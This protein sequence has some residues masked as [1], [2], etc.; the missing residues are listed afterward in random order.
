LN[1]QKPGE[2]QTEAVL[3]ADSRGRSG[4]ATGWR[5]WLLSATARAGVATGFL[6]T[7]AVRAQ[8]GDAAMAALALF[9]AA[10]LILTLVGHWYIVRG[11]VRR[12]LA[13]DAFAVLALVPAAIVAAGIQGAED[14]FGGR[15]ANV[16]AALGATVLIFAIV[17]LIAQMDERIVFGE[18]AIGALG[19]A[20]TVAVLI[21]NPNRFT[22]ADSWQALTIA[23]M[24]AALATAVFGLSPAALRSAIP[25]VVYA[26]FALVV[27]LL[28]VDRPTQQ[29]GAN[30][31]S[32]LALLVAGATMVLVA[33][34][35][36]SR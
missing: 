34:A 14:R 9:I 35:N 23:W 6:L 19:G 22:T 12:D 36:S 20:L 27:V 21:G 28:P 10:A 16:L 5:T 26:L 30:T 24:V 8:L 7:P 13:A 32:I 1:A 15:T 4:V 11:A 3:W 25:I 29:S 31:L 17:A 2:F 33:P 18:A